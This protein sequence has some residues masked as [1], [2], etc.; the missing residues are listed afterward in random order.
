LATAGATE[1]TL[2]SYFEPVVAAGV[3]AAF[4]GQP[5]T[6]PTAGGFLAVVGGFAVIER[7]RLVR[8]LGRRLAITLSGAADH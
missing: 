1:T 5:I 6:A 7:N 4:L 3:A 8:V 2:V